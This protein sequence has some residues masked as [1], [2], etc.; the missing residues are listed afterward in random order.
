MFLRRQRCPFWSCTEMFLITVSDAHIRAGPQTE[1]CNA[2]FFELTKGWVRD[3]GGQP[4]VAEAPPMQA[5]RHS[6]H[7][8]FIA[9]SIPMLQV[10]INHRYVSTG[11]VGRPIN[12]WKRCRYGSKMQSSAKHASAASTPH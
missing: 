4:Q 8:Q 9:Q 12:V 2:R 10:H 5:V 1:A 6:L 7:Q 11:T 3:G